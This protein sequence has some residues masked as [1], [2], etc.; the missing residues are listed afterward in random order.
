MKNN[1]IDDGVAGTNKAGAYIGGASNITVYID[2][3]NFSGNYYPFVMRS[4]G[5]KVDGVKHYESNISVYISNSS[6]H[7]AKFIVMDY[8]IITSGLKYSYTNVTKTLPPTGRTFL[9]G[10][11]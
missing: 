7:F 4:S 11:R 6:I 5:Y 2:N 1:Y 8:I 3:C 9:L 10:M